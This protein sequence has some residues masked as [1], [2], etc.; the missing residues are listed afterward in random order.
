MVTPRRASE[1]MFS[2]WMAFSG[3][4]RGTSTSGRLSLKHTSAARRSKLS[5]R[6]CAMAATVAMLHGTTTIPRVGNVPLAMGA[7]KSPGCIVSK[8][9][10]V[11][12]AFQILAERLVHLLLPH[13]ATRRGSGSNNR[14]VHREKLVYSGPGEYSATGP[15][16]PHHY[17]TSILLRQAKP[18]RKTL[19]LSYI[20]T[21]ISVAPNTAV[22]TY[23]LILK[24]AIPRCEA[25]LG[26]TKR[27]LYTSNAA[28]TPHP[29]K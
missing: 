28:A 26:E 14:Y 24:N 10:V 6:P 17:R 15:G 7:F 9:P 21:A 12:P 25:F 13:H 18:P 2:R 20:N 23:A 29:T 4:S 11:A 3:V 22:E 8:V 1:A 16:D 5:D 27:C 19:W